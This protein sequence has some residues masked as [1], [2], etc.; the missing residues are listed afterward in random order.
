MANRLQWVGGAAMI[1]SAMLYNSGDG[2][3]APS[4]RGWLD[5]MFYV[6]S[7]LTSPW[8]NCPRPWDQVRDRRA[9]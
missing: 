2:S 9:S 4:L 6:P 3:V 1:L 8:G 5:H 7:R